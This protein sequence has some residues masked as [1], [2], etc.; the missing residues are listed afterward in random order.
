MARIA[1]ISGSTEVN[2]FAVRRILCDSFRVV[3]CHEG[4]KV[5]MQRHPWMRL[6]SVSGTLVALCNLGWSALKR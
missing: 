3:L 6:K 1:K 2:G 4:F 5:V